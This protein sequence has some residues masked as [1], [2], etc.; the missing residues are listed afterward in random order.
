MDVLERIRKL[1]LERNW[2]EYQLAERSGLTQSTISTWYRKNIFPTIPSLEKICGAFNMSLAQF[3]TEENCT[4]T[5]LSE[6]Q[7]ALIHNFNRLSET[8]QN[9]VQQL[10]VC[11]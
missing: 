5:T 2:S 4:Q 6:K 10:L 7:S 8:Q 11:I 9:A 1:R 3:F